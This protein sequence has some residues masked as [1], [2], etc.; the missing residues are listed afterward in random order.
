MILLA[1]LYFRSASASEGARIQALERH[2]T[3][4]AREKRSV[5]HGPP[6]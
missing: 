3:L 5:F 4:L 2:A 1:D 6:F